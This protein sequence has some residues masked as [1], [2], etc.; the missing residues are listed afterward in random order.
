MTGRKPR[1]DRVELRMCACG[2]EVLVARH[3]LTGDVIGADFTI[4][5]PV[6]EAQLVLAGVPTYEYRHDGAGHSWLQPRG[7]NTVR[8]RLEG[9]DN[10]DQLVVVDHRCPLTTEV[11][12]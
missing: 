3:I 2:R 5:N 1:E 7:V 8:R 4:P 9:L 10:P 6:E 11:P 12:A